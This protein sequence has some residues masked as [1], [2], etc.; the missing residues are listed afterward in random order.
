MTLATFLL[1]VAR[2]VYGLFFLVASYRNVRGLARHRNAK[3]NYGWP[4]PV[5]MLWIGFAVQALGGL[6]L[7]FNIYPIWGALA[8]IV[9]LIPATTLYH[10]CLLFNGDERGRHLYFVLV[11]CTL[12]AGLLFVIGTSLA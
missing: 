2:I 1:A 7:I 3:T 4:L 12:V 9:F 11:N 10:N 8:L 6:S 5:P